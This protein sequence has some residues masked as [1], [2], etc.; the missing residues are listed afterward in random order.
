MT[1]KNQEK[2]KK[3]FING[4]LSVAQSKGISKSQIKNNCFASY[5]TGNRRLEHNF[6]DLTLTEII[7]IAT[8]CH[9]NPAVFINLAVKNM[10]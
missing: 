7:N 9:V 6:G 3:Q 10:E 5:A 4:M 2:A 1:I 8:F